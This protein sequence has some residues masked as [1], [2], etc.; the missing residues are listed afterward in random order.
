MFSYH[1]AFSEKINSKYKNKKVPLQAH[2]YDD[3]DMPFGKRMYKTSLAYENMGSATV[4][5]A[6]IM[7]L[8]LMAIYTLYIAAS[9]LMTKNQVYEGFQ[10]TIQYMAE[11]EYLYEAISS[12]NQNEKQ[13]NVGE[14]AVSQIMVMNK[15]ED[16]IDDTSLVERYIS[17]G[18][19][20]IKCR[21]AYCSSYDNY[22]YAGLSYKL[23]ADVPF[24]GSLNMTVTEQLKQK[25]YTGMSCSNAASDE[26]NTYVYV[27]EN[28]S[29]YHTTRSCYHISLSIHET[30]KSKLDSEFQNLSPCEYCAKNKTGTG[31]VY[32]TDT[33]D[34]YHYTLSC[35][36]LKRT[37]YRVKKS[38]AGGLPPCSACG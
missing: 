2:A 20:G 29:V 34:R 35:S 7:P 16:Y 11:Y 28:G 30:D 14:A 31:N 22:V 36:G 3:S 9:F 32:I 24:F 27:T 13:K 33:G 10:E 8:F 18:A 5:A 4:E 15:L 37:V 17:G 23:T 6:L 38:E 19:G 1:K 21:Y 12:D 25:A 26:E